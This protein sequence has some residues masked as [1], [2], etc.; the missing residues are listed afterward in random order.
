MAALDDGSFSICVGGFEMCG[1]IRGRV[2]L[3]RPSSN[4]RYIGVGVASLSK[5]IY[6]VGI[7]IWLTDEIP[8]IYTW[9]SGIIL[10][11]ITIH[12]RQLTHKVQML[13]EQ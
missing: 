10:Y 1:T 4:S 8:V 7:F 13:Q 2:L 12:E 6:R 5:C 11:L 3:S 9:F